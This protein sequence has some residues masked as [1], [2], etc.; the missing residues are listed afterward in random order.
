MV[1]KA[2]M[3]QKDQWPHDLLKK[4]LHYALKAPAQ[5]P[6]KHTSLE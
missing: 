2:S 4:S 3:L 6:P 5:S 1:P